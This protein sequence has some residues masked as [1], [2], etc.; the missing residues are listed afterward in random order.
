MFK[1]IL[2]TIG[3]I[4]FFAITVCN[5]NPVKPTTG[6]I[7]GNVT[8]A[9]GDT[10]IAGVIVTT[11]PPTSSVTTDSQ[12]KY[13]ISEVSPGRYTVLASKGGF[14]PGSVSISVAA[15]LITPANIH[16]NYLAGNGPHAAIPADFVIAYQ[17]DD[18]TESRGIYNLS[19]IN[20]VSFSSGKF[21]KSADFGTANTNKYLYQNNNVG[22][23]GGSITMSVWVKLRTE[24]DTGQY[25]FMYQM[26]GS[27]SYAGYFISYQSINSPRMVRFGRQREGIGGPYLTHNITL[28]INDWYHFCLTYDGTNIVGY[29][30]GSAVEAPVVNTGNGS[31]GYNVTGIAF[32][33][34]MRTDNQKTLCFANA[35]IDNAKI[36]NRVLSAD[37][38]SALYNE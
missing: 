31:T 10:A 34:Y 9:T 36:Y 14:N 20:N 17:L 24:I 6:S 26:G 21:G 38:I 13:I 19:N 37:E 30:N 7:E 25:F 1:F 3:F 12:G 22:I 18:S 2:Q 23:C 15:G 35:C 27:P 32:G 5:K 28:G 4:L 33:A 29:I 16:L 8:N 11:T